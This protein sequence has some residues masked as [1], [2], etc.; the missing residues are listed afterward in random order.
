MTKK[1]S[2]SESNPEQPTQRIPVFDREFRENLGWRY[3]NDKN[4]ADKILDLVTDTMSHP[5]EGLGKPEP[6]KHL[7]ANTWSRRI[8]LEHRLVYRVRHD[9]VDFLSCRYHY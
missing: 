1:K 2:P 9:R 8:D 7:E 5:F 3:K 6:L 4:K